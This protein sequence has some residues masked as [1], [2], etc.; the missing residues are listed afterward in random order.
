MDTTGPV[1]F[2]QGMAENEGGSYAEYLN[3]QARQKGHRSAVSGTHHYGF[4][5]ECD[6]CASEA[7]EVRR[8]DA[9]Q[10]LA[11]LLAK[12]PETWP[13]N[14]T[15]DLGDTTVLLERDVTYGAWRVVS[16]FE[17]PSD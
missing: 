11:A 6:T 14:R 7:A 15:I 12:A 13:S 8:R 16:R 10:E 1:R 2:D 17:N 5:G 3:E 9:Q 4:L